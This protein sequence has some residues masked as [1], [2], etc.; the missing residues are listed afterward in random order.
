[1]QAEPSLYFCN[2]PTGLTVGNIGTRATNE[3]D[4]PQNSRGGSQLSTLASL[5]PRARAGNPTSV[6]CSKRANRRSASGN[7]W[8]AQHPPFG[9]R[10]PQFSHTNTHIHTTPLLRLDEDNASRTSWDK[11]RNYVPNTRQ[12]KE[13][14]AKLERTAPSR[15]ESVVSQGGRIARTT[16]PGLHTVIHTQNNTA[17]DQP[18]RHEA[19]S[20]WAQVPE[21]RL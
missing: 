16:E 3:Q 4:K 15:W 8:P 1:M 18:R 2:G 10:A 6:K 20:F 21:M 11:Q 19:P 5:L 9:R 14:S 7:R 12:A 17:R 13:S